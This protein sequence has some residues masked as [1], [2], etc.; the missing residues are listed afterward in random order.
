M[1]HLPED[2]HAPEASQ[3]AT[4]GQVVFLVLV[5]GKIVEATVIAVPPEDWPE[6][7]ES[8]DPRWVGRLV[9]DRMVAMRVR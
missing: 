8:A 5:E 9:G 1:A 7:P 2:R 4:S 3:A 6:C